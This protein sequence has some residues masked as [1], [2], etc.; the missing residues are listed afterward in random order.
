MPGP[1]FGSPTAKGPSLGSGPAGGFGAC[2]ASDHPASLPLHLSEDLIQAPFPFSFKEKS[3][4]LAPSPP[5]VCL[6][7]ILSLSH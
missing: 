3:I 5:Q 6:P 7:H 4:H 1:R 2:V